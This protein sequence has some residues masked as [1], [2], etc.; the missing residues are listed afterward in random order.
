[1]TIEPEFPRQPANSLAA[2][3]QRGV[4][5]A[6]RFVRPPRL[7]AEIDHQGVLARV[8]GESGWSNRYAFMVLMSAG[9]A[10]LGLLLS[11][12][13]VIIG[14]MLVSPL[15]GPIIGLG[16]AIAVFDWAEVRKSVAALAAGALI[17][18]AFAAAIVFLSPLT[19]RTPEIMARTRPS[20]FDL[21]VA[22]FSALAGGYATVRGRGETI[23]GVAIATALMPPL[24]VVGFGLATADWPVFSG[25]LAL[26]VTNFVAIALSATVMAKFY[27]F[28]SHLSPEQSRM[29]G[30][31][32]LGVFLVLAVPLGIS[33]RQIAWETLFTRT[34][35]EV[36]AAEFGREARIDS[37]EPDFYGRPVELRAVVLTPTFKANA[38]E[39]LT[40][41]LEARLD[42]PFTLSLHQVVLDQDPRA[43]RAAIEPVRASALDLAAAGL[44]DQLALL[45]GATDIT[46]DRDS[47]RALVR[48]PPGESLPLGEIRRLEAR[49]AARH[50]EWEVRLVPPLAPLPP[51]LFAAGSAEPDQQAIDTLGW[52]L[53]RW[54]I[55]SVRVVGRAASDEPPGLA[56]DRAEA[57]A[58]GLERSGVMA[59]VDARPADAGSR[60]EEREK[61]LA[62]ARSAGI[63]L[64]P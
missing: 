57:V 10:I 26:F 9:I 50:P 36:I 25:A 53:A 34:A 30:W 52:A 45:T 61:G 8:E 41:A 18:I 47:R 13:A 38:V 4:E 59:S 14:A 55:P 37:L 6:F 32:I 23:V 2:G 19:D 51:I 3:V 20:L 63:S 7:L 35:R 5:S 42:T 21:L 29:Q 58:E 33:L 27:G 46:L 17:A 15:M 28:G 56:R 49:L 54:K 12:P 24:A 39:R 60:A 1:M 48:L 11:S 62:A 43:I 16:F 40:A 44:R 22:V 31:A 64:L